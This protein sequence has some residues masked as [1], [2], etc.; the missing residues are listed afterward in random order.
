MN[1]NNLPYEELIKKIKQQQ[2]E[3][4]SFQECKE[5]LNDFKSFKKVSQDLI[6]VIGIDGFYKEINPAFVKTVGYSERELLSNSITSFIHPDDIVNTNN[7]IKTLSFGQ[8]SIN[9]ENRYIKKNKEIVTIEWTI[10]KSISKTYIH[11]FG[12]DVTEI[13]K[14]YNEFEVNQRLLNETQKINKI[15]SWELDLNTK[16]VIWSDE[17]YLI[18]EIEKD[19]KKDLFKEYLNRF[20]KKNI[21]LFQNKIDQLRTNKKTFEVERSIT[22]LNNRVKWLYEIITPLLDDTGIVTG[23]RVSTQDI[24]AKRQIEESIKAKQQSETVHKIKVIEEV[25]NTKFKHYIEHSPD[26]VFVTDLLGNYLEVNPASTTFT[27][28]SKEELLKMKFGDL[29]SPETQEETRNKFDI[30]L[31]TGSLKTEV[32]TISKNGDVRWRS[33]DVVKL[34]ENRF[35]GFAKDIT[36]SKRTLEKVT[37]NEKRF[38]ALLENNE[39]I[40]SLVDKNFNVVFRSASASRITGWEYGEFE[41]VPVAHYVYPDDLE[42]VKEIME[43]ASANPGQIFP[44]LFR[45]KHKEGHYLW[46]EGVVNNM[47]HIPEIGGTITNI[48]DVTANKKAEEKLKEERDKFAKI[49]ATSPG[50]IYSMRQNKDGSLCYPYASNAIEEIYGFT[51]EEIEHDPN[52]IFSLVHPDDLGFMMDKIIKT[53]S[54]MVP[55]KGEYRY[56]HPKKGLV[57]HDVNSLP[58]IEPEGTVICHGIVTDVSERKKAEHLLQEERDKLAIISAASPGLIYSFIQNTDGSFG[59]PYASSAI[60]EIF[61]FNFEEIEND[62]TK[63]FDLSNW[64]DR[65]NINKRIEESARDLTPWKNE[66]RYSHPRKGN[67][68]LEGNSIPTRDPSGATLWHGVI[69]DITERK[70]AEKKIIKASRLY[71]FISQMNQMIV[72]VTDQKSLFI[73]ACTIAVELGK[74]KMAWIGM[75]DEDNKKVIP[76]MIAGEDNGYHSDIDFDLTDKTEKGKGPIVTTIKEGKYCVCNDIENDIQIRPWK[77]E[78]IDRGYLSLMTL[79]IKKFG[80]TIGAFAFY[81]EEKDFFDAEEIALLEKATEDVCFAIEIIEKET[82]RKK[83]VQ[84]VS[85][86]EQRYNTL[87]EVSPVGIFRTDADGNTTYVNSKWCQISGVSFEE[88]MGEGWIKAVHDDDREEL[89]NN[90]KKSTALK[91]VNNSEFRFLRSDNTITWVMGQA[92]PEK[93]SKNEIVGYIGTATDITERKIS[94]D[95][96]LKEK[97]LSET[98][99]N[100]LPGIFYLYEKSGKLVK[101]NKNF[102]KVTG[103]N[104]SEIEKM[105]PLDFFDDEEK[106][107]IRTRAKTVFEKESAGIEVELYTKNKHKMPYFVNSI[108]IEYEGKKC[109]LGMGLDLSE[110]RK[111]E[112]EI[113][114]ANQRFEMI[115]IATNDAI[116]E[117]DLVTGYS[118]NNKSFIELLNFG[119]ESFAEIDN[120]SIWRS[121]LH[122]D[123]SER[124][125]KKLEETYAGT[126]TTWSDEFRFQ[127]A[128]GSYGNFYDR[129]IIIRDEYGR[130]IRFIGSMLD[131]TNLKKAE[132]EFREIN[133]KME[134]ILDAIPDLLFEIGIDGEIY[135]YHSKQDDLLTMSAEQFLGKKFSDVL[136][137]EAADICL[138]AIREASEKGFSSGHQYTLILPDGLHW[139]ELSIAPMEESEDHDTHFICL[140]RDITKAKLA[141]YALLKSEERYRGLLHNLDAGIVVHAPDTSI[142]YKNQEAEEILGLVDLNIENIPIKESEWCFF[143]E[144]NSRMSFDQYP[145][146]QILDSKK[147]IKNVVVGVKRSSKN[148]I[149]WILVNGFPVFIENGIINEVVISFIDIT[150]RI[151]IKSELIKAKEDAEA[152]NRA[153]TD[154][155]A[156]MSHEIRTPLNGIIGF[157]HLLMKSDLK[158]NQFEYMSTVNESA[159]L[160][161]HIVNDVLDFSKI[162]SG[163]FELNV[164]K[165]NLFKLAS[166]VID[167]FKY[168]V[169]QKKLDLVFNIEEKVPQYVLADSLR[170]K[171]ILVNL[172]SNAV[173]FT[174]SG[175]IQLKI[176]A[177]ATSEENETIIKFSVKDTGIGIKYDNSEKIFKSFVQEDNSTNRKFGGTGLGLAISN[178]LLALMGSK[179]ELITKYGEGSD[180]F[181][182]IK[183][184]T[185]PYNAKK[186]SILTN[187]TIKN[188]L[189]NDNS[190]AFSEEKEAKILI[191]EDN[192]INMLLAKTLVKKII[193]NCVIFEANDGVE[194]VDQYNKIKPD[195]IL[196]DIQMPNKN[197]YEAT[198]EIRK[199][200]ESKHIPIIAITAGILVGDKEKCIAAGMNDYLPKPIIQYDLERIL[201][202]W[203]YK[204]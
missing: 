136:P 203:V 93:N 83:A 153:K 117:V 78:A 13:K 97:Q 174:S 19:T 92:I 124:V 96:I 113:R 15:G 74:F 170:L 59:F 183:F 39:G 168:Q 45:I 95:I 164:D 180:F 135:N 23:I 54:E 129:A 184:K 100:N 62:A 131:I 158:E 77:K 181:F 109:L 9:F 125:I 133:K 81:S 118:W 196:M 5:L 89:I 194:A 143:N 119:S 151:L 165:I 31:K 1:E 106:E 37:Q 197:G 172:L 86:S 63:I 132:E 177:I 20:S 190:I 61:G 85:E 75:V 154:F 12:R 10:T 58:E 146:C 112:E 185:P 34:P 148:D 115:S 179:L 4:D 122:P 35:L 103:Y 130:A 163:K 79:P 47:S 141:D 99:I 28:Y 126:S 73:E 161:M 51:H 67:I 166:Q 104:T 48:R 144:D 200:K 128:D 69:I 16:N 191:V 160:L 66:F 88:A 110:Q 80:N 29:S 138:L 64:E 111:V 44:V 24:S 147:S 21:E 68:W 101:W 192:K 178:Q 84:A 102:E 123:D 6:C 156:N 150:T 201:H 65:I 169:N 114:I 87:A 198:Q 193:P 14:T 3:I 127:R 2:L 202:K 90:W 52:K 56:L 57:W 140:S 186:E 139:F 171:Q 43:N 49:A 71:L 82:L 145:V 188:T 94:E 36:E 46:M 30:L 53:K 152:A 134:A 76:V 120:R 195:V 159:S 105:H 50:L 155:L 173:K 27:G 91:E 121:K 187:T 189:I 167:L 182:V 98:V 26:S 32:K 55:L 70:I 162:E 204:K 38:R 42:H 25:S 41:K 8:T 199:I 60:E 18:F 142:I 72:R 11:A 17:L 176:N 40:I 175:S 108:A 7:T 22:F 149:V 157:T 107:K 116:F 137:K 33:L